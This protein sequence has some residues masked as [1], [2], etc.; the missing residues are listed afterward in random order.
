PALRGL[1]W[2]DERGDRDGDGFYEYETRSPEG[3]RNQ[4]WKD[5]GDAIVHADGTIADTPVA[6]CEVQAYAFVAKRHL[7]EI[8]WWLG[9]RDDA[10]RLFHEASELRKRFNERFWMEAEG[11]YAMGLDGGKALIR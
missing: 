11:Y 1:R 4:G 5:S 7:S 10:R 8:L 3:L 9:D 2:L 6:T